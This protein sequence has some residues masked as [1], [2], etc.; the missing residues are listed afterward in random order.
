[1]DSRQQ[2]LGAAPH[3]CTVAGALCTLGGAHEQESVPLP[4]RLVPWEVISAG[5]SLGTSPITICCQGVRPDHLFRNSMFPSN[6]MAN[7]VDRATSIQVMHLLIVTVREGKVLWKRTR[8][9]SDEETEA[10]WDA[11]PNNVLGTKIEK[12]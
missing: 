10:T 8:E 12:S 9:E 5:V 3:G 7:M 1:M 2:H 4:D 6:S 11:E